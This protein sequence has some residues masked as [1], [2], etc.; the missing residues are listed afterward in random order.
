MNNVT[1][2]DD[3]LNLAAC[4]FPTNLAIG[5][6]VQC[7]ISG[8]VHCD[9]VTNTVTATG[10]GATSGTSTN[11]TDTAAVVIQAIDITCSLTVNGSS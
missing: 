1:V 4:N 6:S 9:N 11:A 10:V 7:I 2:V 3:V 8:V 5:Q